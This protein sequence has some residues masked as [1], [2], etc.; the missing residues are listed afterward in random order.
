[1]ATKKDVI[2]TA[3]PEFDTSELW[4]E[5]TAVL[6]PYE[7][8]PEVPY[9]ATQ[10]KPYTGTKEDPYYD[11]SREDAIGPNYISGQARKMDVFF[12]DEAFRQRYHVQW[13]REHDV[14]IY[15]ARGFQYVKR[16]WTSGAWTHSLSKSSGDLSDK[17]RLAVGVGE[18]G[19][20]EYNILMFMPLEKFAKIEQA[21]HNA[22][23]RQLNLKS[24][25]FDTLSQNLNDRNFVI[26][27]S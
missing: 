19:V 9:K 11:H 18:G 20:T 6:E 2:Q 16:E 7:A 8:T 26:K 25:N 21:V 17:V 15:E 10:N 22:Y 23:N 12:Q 4:A 1:M 3:V 5:E 27:N 24:Q 13:V 14:G